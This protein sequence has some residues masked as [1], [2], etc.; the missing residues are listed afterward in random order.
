MFEMGV[1]NFWGV[2]DKLACIWARIM[3]IQ[4]L[5]QA[6]AAAI[7]EVRSLVFKLVDTR[8]VETGFLRG[9]LYANVSL[10]HSGVD[11]VHN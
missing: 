9:L 4:K 7:L 11:T 8:S 10:T 1:I 3:Y 5:Q 2:G 6:W